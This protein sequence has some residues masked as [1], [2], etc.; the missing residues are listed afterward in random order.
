VVASPVGANVEVVTPDT[1]FLAADAAAWKQTLRNLRDDPALRRQLGRAAR[2]RV[3]QHYSLQ[4]TAP[5][6]VQLINSLA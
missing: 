5:A 2:Q 3:Q 4:V 6:L 1:G